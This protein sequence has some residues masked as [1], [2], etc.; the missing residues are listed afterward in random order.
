MDVYYQ[1]QRETLRPGT[2]ARLH[3]NLWQQG[4]EA[5]LTAEDWGAITC[6]Y[7]VPWE[8]RSA[9]A[10]VGVDAAT[11]RDCAAVVAVGWDESGLL[12]VLAHNIW[13]L[14]RV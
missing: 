1:E 3:L 14:R 6:E 5:F 4:E 13:T 9:R 7:A 12:A 2:F 11:K 8:E 10:F